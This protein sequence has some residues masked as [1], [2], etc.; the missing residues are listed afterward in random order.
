MNTQEKVVILSAELAGHVD[1][2]ARTER[3]RRMLTGLHFSNG[4]FANFKA[5]KGYYKGNYEDNFI[6]LLKDSEWETELEM[7]KDFAFENFGQEAI[8]FSDAN[9]HT[10]LIFQDGTES[11]GKLVS[12]SKDEAETFENYT[13]L[14]QKRKGIVSNTLYFVTKKLN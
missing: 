7:L 6:V 14:E 13:V 3:L 10:E 1:N 11:L 4:C 2:A 9:R 12:V 8:L 5:A